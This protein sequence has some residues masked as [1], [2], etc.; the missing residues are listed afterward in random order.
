MCV[1]VTVLCV[2]VCVSVVRARLRETQRLP[3]RM[4]RGVVLEGGDSGAGAGAAALVTASLGSDP[5]GVAQL[6]AAVSV[7]KECLSRSK[8]PTLPTPLYFLKY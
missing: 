5:C 1:C 4:R 3:A 2:C 6:L 8:N 7:A